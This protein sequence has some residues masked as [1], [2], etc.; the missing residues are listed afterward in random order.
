V[1]PEQALHPDQVVSHQGQVAAVA[2][3]VAPADPV[4]VEVGASIRRGVGYVP[5][6]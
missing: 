6:V 3:V 2:P 5:S 1:L 4:V